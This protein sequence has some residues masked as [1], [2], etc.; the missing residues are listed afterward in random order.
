MTVATCPHCGESVTVPV[1]VAPETRVACPLCQEELNGDDFLHQLPPSLLLLDAPAEAMPTSADESPESGQM[2]LDPDNPFGEIREGDGGAAVITRV[3]RTGTPRERPS[4]NGGGARQ[5]ISIVLGGMLALPIA[6]LILWQLNRDPIALVEKWSLRDVGWLQWALPRD[7]RPTPEGQDQPDPKGSA[8]ALDSPSKSN[9]NNYFGEG[10]SQ[11]PNPD[12]DSMPRTFP[13][14]DLAGTDGPERP[15]NDTPIPSEPPLEPEVE[16]MVELIDGAPR[17]TSLILAA[18]LEQTRESIAELDNAGDDLEPAELEQLQQVYCGGLAQL[19]HAV[20]FADYGDPEAEQE[21]ENVA[22]LLKSILASQPKLD[23]IT[24]YGS[25]Q[26]GSPQDGLQGIVLL[27][28]IIEIKEQQP[29]FETVLRL[30]GEEL[31]VEVT[32]ISR[33]NPTPPLRP[34]QQ[35]LILGSATSQPREIIKGYEGLAEQVVI[36]GYPLIISQPA[37]K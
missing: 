33:R 9:S 22:R 12:L 18:V 17:Y 8:S 29:F 31:A 2:E 7:D 3:R 11:Y 35:V 24:E 5:I 32:I 28:E 14:N 21:V 16:A 1:G 19:A 30:P 13:P 36:G 4:R 34:G 37:G 26:Y 23:L 20:T 27:G 10:N 15:D 6:Q 25:F